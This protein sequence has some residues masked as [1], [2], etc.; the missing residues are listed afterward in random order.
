VQITS[1]ISLQ[2]SATNFLQITMTSDTRAVNGSQA[3]GS[4][5]RRPAARADERGAAAVDCSGAEGRNP[6]IVVVL[7]VHV[8][9]V[10][11]G[12]PRSSA[13]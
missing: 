11:G 10:K 9:L 5:A 4:P 7:V 12:G 6:L 8:G 3:G 13:A 2:F 1:A